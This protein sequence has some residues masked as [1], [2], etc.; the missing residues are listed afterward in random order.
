MP[1]VSTSSHEDRVR[2]GALQRV[3]A[4]AQRGGLPLGVPAR[5]GHPARPGR[6]QLG[7]LRQA[8]PEHDDHRVE[9]GV[10]QRPHAAGHQGL[11][12]ELD[13]RL[14]PTHPPAAAGGEQETGGGTQRLI[15]VTGCS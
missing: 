3:Q 2:V 13:G 6:Q 8:G 12:V 9:P 1:G 7:D 11:A 15:S 5:C 10:A 14:G 4:G